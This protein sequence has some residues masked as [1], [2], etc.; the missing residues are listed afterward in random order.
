MC[1]S[2]PETCELYMRA[3]N[4]QVY[5]CVNVSALRTCMCVFSF[6]S[7]VSQ[8]RQGLRESTVADL[9]VR[10]GCSRSGGVCV[11]VCVLGLDCSPKGREGEWVKPAQSVSMEL[12]FVW[13]YASCVYLGGPWKERLWTFWKQEA[14]W[15]FSSEIKRR[16]GGERCVCVYTSACMSDWTQ[17]ECV[18]ACL[19]N[20]IVIL[21]LSSFCL[22]SHSRSVKT[23]L[24]IGLH[25]YWVK[26]GHHWLFLCKNNYK[27]WVR[28]ISL[29]TFLNRCICV[30][31]FK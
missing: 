29:Y 16:V 24:F 14:R 22:H 10:G 27:L 30:F 13:V 25:T 31:I 7:E 3:G 26:Q 17:A 28:D 9:S 20:Y 23:S 5:M 21:A 8:G 6:G 19:F 11:C 2:V 12:P 15:T 4:F 18:C 1:M